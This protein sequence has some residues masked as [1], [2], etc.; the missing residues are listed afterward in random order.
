MAESHQLWPRPG[1]EPIWPWPRTSLALASNLV[2][3]NPSLLYIMYKEFHHPIRK[4]AR[5]CSFQRNDSKKKCPLL[6]VNVLLT[7]RHKQN[8][9][10]NYILILN[11]AH[12]F[13]I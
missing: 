7:H 4:L 12:N 9:V 8:P 1:L 2:S 3:S 13:T 6:P 5:R 11:H 10:D